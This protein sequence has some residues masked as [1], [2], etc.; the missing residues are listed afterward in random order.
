MGKKGILALHELTEEQKETIQKIAPDYELVETKEDEL[1]SDF[2]LE[3]IEVVYGWG[4]LGEQVAFKEGSRLNW[5]QTASAGVDYLPL[6]QLEERE[7]ALTNASGIHSTAISES[8]FAMLFN[9]TRGIGHALLKQQEK[10]W[11]PVESLVE[12]KNRTMMIVGTGHIGKETGRIAKAFG[13]KTIG[14]NRS[15]R[16]VDYMD[17]LF[18]QDDLSQHLKKA[19]VVVNILPLTEQ[20]EHF[21]NRD[22]FKEMKN[23]AIFINVG[24]GGTVRTTDL[25]DALDNGEL[26]HAAL[27]VFEEEPLPED[28]P[29]WD[30]EDVLITPHFSGVLEDY[31]ASLFPIFEEN[32][33]AFVEG[34]ELPRN[35][36]DYKKGY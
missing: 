30:R 24:R 36:V 8:I 15:G 1:V 2:P 21:F 19:D 26:A 23:S 33:K 28:D 31:E 9:H 16:E 3:A 13:M 27:D 6:E 12:L 22:L 29:L 7:V 34:K 17:E 35:V 5:V 18:T 32:L 14:I 25:I 4:A 10:K 20:T 11:D